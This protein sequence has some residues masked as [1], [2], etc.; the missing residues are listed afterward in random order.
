MQ[1]VE[2]VLLQALA[3]DAG[4]ASNTANEQCILQG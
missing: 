4:V 3:T 2:Y 1:H